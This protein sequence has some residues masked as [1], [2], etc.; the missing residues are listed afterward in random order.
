M[1]T[2]TKDPH[3]LGS[4]RFIF[5]RSLVVKDGVISVN[6]IFINVLMVTLIS[7]NVNVYDDSVVAGNSV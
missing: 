6:P 1:I 3:Q 7:S 4:T 5:L 2:S